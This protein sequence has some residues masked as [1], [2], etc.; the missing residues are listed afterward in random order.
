MF[1]YSHDPSSGWLG[2]FESPVAALTSGRARYAD[3]DKIFIAQWEPAYYADF[4]PS[5]EILISMMREAVSDRCGDAA[6]DVYD[7]LSQDQRFS[8]GAALTAAV[9]EWEDNLP[10]KLE[11]TGRRILKIV[12]YEPRDE[13][14]KVDF[15]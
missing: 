3:A 8:L 9:E 10:S 11:F 2:H 6:A 12:G 4:L 14:R 13:V 1:S 15:P 7:L 5:V